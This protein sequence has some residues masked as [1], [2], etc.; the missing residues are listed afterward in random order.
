MPTTKNI[1]FFDFFFPI[2]VNPR[3]W[4]HRCH[5]QLW[6]FLQRSFLPVVFIDVTLGFY[7]NK[8]PDRLTPTSLNR[9]YHSG[10]EWNQKQLIKRRSHSLQTFQSSHQRPFCWVQF[11]GYDNKIS[12]F[13]K[14]SNVLIKL[15]TTP[16]IGRRRR[17]LLF[18]RYLGL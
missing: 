5:I 13:I 18:S 12:P 10:F 3:I 11:I 15:R 6:S 17:F 16:N 14:C 9:F 7:F 1:D 2:S 8:N 4:P